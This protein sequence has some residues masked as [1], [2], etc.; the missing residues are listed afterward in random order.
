MKVNICTVLH[1][2]PSSEIE[3]PVKEWGE[4]KGWFVKWDTLHYTLDGDNWNEIELNNNTD[5]AVEWKRPVEVIVSN[6]ETFEEIERME[7]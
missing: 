4:I 7:E 6:P 1:C 5:E 3:L 2:A